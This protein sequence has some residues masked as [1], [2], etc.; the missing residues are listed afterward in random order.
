MILCKLS[1][2]QPKMNRQQRCQRFS[3]IIIC[4][5]LKEGEE[6]KKHKKVAN[7]PIK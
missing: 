4:L 5:K 1:I 6:G 2:I 3:E 7:F